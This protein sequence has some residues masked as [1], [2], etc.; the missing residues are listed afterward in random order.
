MATEA[1]SS[2]DDGGWDARLH[3]EEV[4][5]FVSHFEG[6]RN[7]DFFDFFSGVAEATKAFRDRSYEAR[8]FD[9]EQGDD[10]LTESGFFKALGI[11]LSLREGALTLLGPPCSLWVFF[12]SPFHCRTKSNPAGDTTKQAGREANT[13]VRNVCL[14][15]AIGHFRGVFFILEQPG[16]S[17]L[18]NYSWIVQLS[19]T[20][21]LRRVFTWMRCFGHAIPKPTYLLC[22]MMSAK[23]LRRVWSAQRE[24]KRKVRHGFVRMLKIF[25]DN[26]G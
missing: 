1:A 16:S 11:V 12:S 25:F 10:L 19:E 20:L 24:L 18:E 8:N 23:K 4:L 21:G 5:S 17:R 13:L 7:V 15:L 26:R 9:L 22:N 2:R 3:L 14:L 6:G